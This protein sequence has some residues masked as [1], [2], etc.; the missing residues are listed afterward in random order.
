M[1]TPL[2]P[3][4]EIFTA[5]YFFKFV[6]LVCTNSARVDCFSNKCF[7]VTSWWVYWQRCANTAT[8]SSGFQDLLLSVMHQYSKNFHVGGKPKHTVKHCLLKH[9]L[10]CEVIVLL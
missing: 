2:P 4:V 3:T 1:K 7:I 6:A 8:N 9:D 10:I 5:A